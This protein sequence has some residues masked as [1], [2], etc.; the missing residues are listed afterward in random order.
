MQ[1][2]TTEQSGN[3][4]KI[5]SMQHIYNILFD[6]EQ[7]RHDRYVTYSTHR[8]SGILLQQRL[9]SHAYPISSGLLISE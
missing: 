3:C 8:Q 4:R 6:A 5:P 1:N 9:K 2:V 7:Q